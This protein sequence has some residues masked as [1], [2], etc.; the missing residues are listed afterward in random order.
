MLVRG[1]RFLNVFSLLFCAI[2]AIYV[3]IYMGYAPGANTSAASFADSGRT[4]AGVIITVTHWLTPL[5]YRD[6]SSPLVLHVYDKY[7][8]SAAP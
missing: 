8:V 5:N 3:I 4:H 6:L 1:R 2:P 7:V